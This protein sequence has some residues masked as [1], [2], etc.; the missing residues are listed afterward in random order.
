MPIDRLGTAERDASS[1]S[2]RAWRSAFPTD[3]QVRAAGEIFLMEV[4]IARGPF[5]ESMS[6]KSV[7]IVGKFG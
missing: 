3:S 4:C 2:S 6:F 5:V 1:S 7:G